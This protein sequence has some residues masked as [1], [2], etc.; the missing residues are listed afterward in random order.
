MIRRPPRSTLFPY[1]T[2][3]RSVFARRHPD[4]DSL[5]VVHHHAVGAAVDPVFLGIAHDDD[6]VGADV[7]AA[8]QLVQEGDRELEHVDFAVAHD[9]FEHGSALHDARRDG[10]MGLHAVTIGAH[11]IQGV[12]RNG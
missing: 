9:V 10:T 5:R 1:T 12:P 3:F 4:A 11:H 6:V 8:V 2:L 7:A